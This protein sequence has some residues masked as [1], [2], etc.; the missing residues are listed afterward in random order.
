MVPVYVAGVSV[1]ANI[2]S[3]LLGVLKKPFRE[4]HNE[5]DQQGAATKS[6]RTH[7]KSLGGTTI[8]TYKVVRA[9]CVFSLLGLYG[10]DFA[11]DI[12]AHAHLEP[13]SK[14]RILELVLFLTYVCLAG[15]MWCND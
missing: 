11:Y 6:I 3:V 8:F 12:N 7:V 5:M 10:H 13:M 2:L 9:V 1:A 15:R 14:D 4:A